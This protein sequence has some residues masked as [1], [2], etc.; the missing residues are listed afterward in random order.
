M[1]GGKY[2]LHIRKIC[3]FLCLLLVF[4]LIVSACAPQ[5]R[6]GT[7]NNY[8]FNMM[9]DMMTTPEARYGMVEMMKTPEIRQ[10]MVEMMKTPE[11][12]QAMVEMMKTP[13]MRQAMVETMKTPEMQAILKEVLKP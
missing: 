1:G 11:M 5:R 8:G 7:D 13:E 12:R 2:I 10:A 9:R 6:P 4:S 3:K